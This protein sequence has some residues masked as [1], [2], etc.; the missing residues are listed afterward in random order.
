MVK[1]WKL[2]QLKQAGGSVGVTSQSVTLALWCRGQQG[3]SQ[4]LREDR[5]EQW[6]EVITGQ[7][8]C[9]FKFVWNGWTES[10]TLRGAAF[11]LAGGTE[12]H[13]GGS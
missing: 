11:P 9:G 12:V 13:R 8:G 4:T 7:E 1:C 3:R 6:Q 2:T 10:W 5:G